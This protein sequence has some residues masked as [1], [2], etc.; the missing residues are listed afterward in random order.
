[1]QLFKSYYRTEKIIEKIRDVLSIGW[2]APGKYCKEFE[3]RWNDFIGCKYSHFVNSCTGALHI[4]LRLLDLPARAKVITTPITFVSTNAVILYEGCIPVFVDIDPDYMC[5]DIKKVL[6][7]VKKKDI[8]AVIWVHYG[9]MVHPKFIELSNKLESMGIPIIEDCA[10]AA[11]AFYSDDTRVG[12]KNIS[13][14]SY[15]AVK[16]MPSFDGGSIVVHTKENYDRVKRLAWLGIS[17][18]TF[19]RMQSESNEIYKWQYDVPE[20]GW[21]YNGNEISAIMALVALEYLDRDNAYR[22][23]IYA[24]YNKGDFTLVSHHLWRSAH[25]LVVA[26][27]DNRDQVVS[28]LKANNIAPGVH[29]MPNFG[30]KPFEKFYKND[31]QTAAKMAEQIISLPNHLFLTKKDIDRVVDIINETQKNRPTK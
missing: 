12:S 18:N 10:H 28:A 5:L 4:A 3:A 1:M 26:K 8:G 31:C 15:Q 14:F 17:Q 19:D 6:E 25:H 16:N 24:W 21:K 7:R 2:T 13:C 29:Y 23:Q 20:L 11:G 30:F 27:V 9:G 22:R